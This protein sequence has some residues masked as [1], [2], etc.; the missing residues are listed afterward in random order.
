MRHYWGEM[1]TCITRN[2]VT[3][4][5]YDRI[6]NVT[7]DH[8]NGKGNGDVECVYVLGQRTPFIPYNITTPFGGRV[9]ALRVEDSGLRYVNRT[10][11]YDGKRNILNF[12]YTFL[13]HLILYIKY[14]QV[15]LS[16]FT[17]KTIS[18]RKFQNGLSKI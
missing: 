10:F 14:S 15:H 11:R 9:R 12:M 7:G 1:Y 13:F 6:V 17:S 4:H 5:H 18:L 8:L 16:T 3:R 2:L